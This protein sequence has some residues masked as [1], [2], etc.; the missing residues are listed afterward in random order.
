VNRLGSSASR[1]G[2]GAATWSPWSMVSRTFF[3]VIGIVGLVVVAALLAPMIDAQ[4]ELSTDDRGFVGTEARCESPSVA[5]A[6]GRTQRSLVAICVEDG[7]YE[8]RGVRIRDDALLTAPAKAVG[9]GV[10]TAA[11]EETTYRFSAK[12][13]R[14]IVKDPDGDDKVIRVEPMVAYVE[15][16]L[17]AEG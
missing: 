11:N 1:A 15:P 10:F 17:A 12:D 16:R 6:F 8:Y 2:I 4:T 5:V 7:A 9:D 14:V 3:V 13:L